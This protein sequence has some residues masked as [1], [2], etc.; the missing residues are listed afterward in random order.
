VEIGD[1]TW[2]GSIVSSNGRWLYDIIIDIVERSKSIARGHLPRP[3]SGSLDRIYHDA[4]VSRRLPYTV[5][6]ICALFTKLAVAESMLDE[7]YKIDATLSSRNAA[8]DN[9]YTLGRIGSHNIVLATL[10]SGS[11]GS[12]S[13][14]NVVSQILST[15]PSIRRSGFGLVWFGG[16]NWGWCSQPRKRYPSW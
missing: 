8:D 3:S 9:H 10:T 1:A 7:I 14:A 2:N 11:T 6:W 15:F 5:G 12:V 13:A 4:L 16:G